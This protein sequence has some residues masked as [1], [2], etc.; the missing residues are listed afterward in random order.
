M[1]IE[2]LLHEHGWLH[3]M[4]YSLLLLLLLLLSR[5]VPVVPAAAV[6]VSLLRT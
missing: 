2:A 3:S 5:C 1:H 6:M 4:S